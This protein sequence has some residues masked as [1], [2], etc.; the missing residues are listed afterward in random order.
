MK[1]LARLV[2]WWSVVTAG[3]GFPRPAPVGGVDDGGDGMPASVC[4]ANQSL[5]CDGDGLVRCNS[6]GTG[7]MTEACSL[8]C[9]ASPL[10]CNEIDPSNDLAR[11]LDMAAGEPDLDLGTTATINTS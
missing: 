5:R 4:T 6:D 8:G 7:E 9:R 3:C 1:R 11:Y 10:H 2:G